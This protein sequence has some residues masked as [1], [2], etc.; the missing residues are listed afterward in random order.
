MKKISLAMVEAVVCMPSV[1][2]TRLSL[3]DGGRRLYVR[4]EWLDAGF[5]VTALDF[6]KAWSCN[7]EYMWSFVFSLVSVRGN[8]RDGWMDG[9]RA[10][11]ISWNLLVTIFFEGVLLALC[12]G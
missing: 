11:R 6:P 3:G 10:G 8:L 12:V 7:G 4:T 9:C 2:C 5:A 1:T